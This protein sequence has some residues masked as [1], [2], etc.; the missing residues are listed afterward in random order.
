MSDTDAL[1]NDI[2]DETFCW[3]SRGDRS[4]SRCG[5]RG[6]VTSSAQQSKKARP[7]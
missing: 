6:G 3:I 1:K 5:W 2:D 4:G 7:Q